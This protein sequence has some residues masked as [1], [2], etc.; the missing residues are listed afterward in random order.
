MPVTPALQPGLHNKT[1]S[2]KKKKN[3]VRTTKMN[4]K[5]RDMGVGR[6][7]NMNSDSVNLSHGI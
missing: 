3:G 2:S 5:D 4:E 6:G 1:L 7:E